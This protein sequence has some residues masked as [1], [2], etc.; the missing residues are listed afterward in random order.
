M[1]DD[2]PHITFP[3]L[4]AL[5]DA[6]PVMLAC[7]D[8]ASRRCVYANAEYAALGRMSSDEVLGKTIE[9]IIGRDAA[10]RVTPQ[11]ALMLAER[12]TVT[13]TRS[14]NAAGDA[15]HWIEV[16]L[17]P[18]GSP[19]IDRAFVMVFD[20]TPNRVAELRSRDS[21]ER[22]GKF[23]QAS[24]E[25]LAFHV[26][27]TIT[28]VNPPLLK[29]LGYTLE[30][31]VG[32]QTLEFVPAHQHP[33]AHRAMA[34]DGEVTYESFA[35]HKSGHEL[36]VEYSARNFE[37]NGRKQRLINVRDLSER[38]AA[39]A[40]IRFLAMHDVLTGLPNRAQ[41]DDQLR[42][43]VDE[44]S[45][46]STPLSVF[47]IDLDQLKRVNDSLGH[48]VGDLL[49]IGVAER[50]REFCERLGH[51]QH[52]PWLARLGGD[53]F[54]IILR[55][56]GQ[57]QTDAISRD[58]QATFQH[59]IDIQGRKIR[60]T[61]S[62]GVAIFP[63]HGST[64][65][66]LLKNADAAMYLAKDAGRDTTRFFDPLLAIRAD[67]ALIVE[68]E[69]DH[70]LQHNEFELFY[71]PEVSSDGTRIVGVEALI[72]WRHQTRGLL[73][74]EEFIPIAEGLYLILPISQWV[75]DTAL[76]EVPR[77][78]ELGWKN[79]RVSV[80]LS[81]NQ[82]R[83]PDFA[84]GVL[85]A[86]AR[87]GLRGD[88]L[89]LEFTERML[90]HDDSSI[91]QMLNTLRA[92]NVTLAVDDFGTGFSS[93]SRLRK[94][95]IEKLKIDRSFIVELPGT[96]SAAAIVNSIFELA[97]GLEL[98]VVAEGVETEAQRQCLEALGCRAMQ[99]FLFARPMPAAEFCAWLKALLAGYSVTVTQATRE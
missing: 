13:Y 28:D 57:P 46:T 58:L 65:S 68:H 29:L 62:V 61:A 81:G 59:P 94:L 6:V 1:S 49:L 16:R 98:T 96:L 56:A 93:L 42:L 39:E 66:E 9:Q 77:W 48:S 14:T 21:S 3:E 79:A 8:I 87:Q 73:G 89:E 67:H 54:V 95:P 80:N 35:I 86:L 37:W 5:T 19:L 36:P 2:H 44:A 74:P 17:V 50:L 47:F 51:V 43:S 32:H 63:H 60:V 20:I 40:R 53:E 30:E 25:G 52:E 88:C 82:V 99:G 92:E 97:R 78:R 26:K 24:Q 4:R 11:L 72:R 31:M 45:K 71:Q 70:A 10:D 55:Q 27:G 34:K 7:F 41:L 90:M 64:P 91:P 83:L 12:R 18:C 15:P 23:M 84:D 69:L 38:R 22:L 76:A 85:R 33:Q 75:L